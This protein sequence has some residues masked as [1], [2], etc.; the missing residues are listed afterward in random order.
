MM[1]RGDSRERY[2]DILSQM[3][4]NVQGCRHQYGYGHLEQRATLIVQDRDG[5]FVVSSEQ[6]LYFGHGRWGKTNPV[7]RQIANIVSLTD[8][9]RIL[10][11]QE[12]RFS[13]IDK[14][15]AEQE[16]E[17][18]GHRLLRPSERN[19]VKTSTHVPCHIVSVSTGETTLQPL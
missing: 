11:H 5:S 14:Q 16:E 17:F 3:R 1:I 2:Q 12:L 9:G 13:E 4:M 18:P 7:D 15:C 8:R 10:F 19:R 6:V